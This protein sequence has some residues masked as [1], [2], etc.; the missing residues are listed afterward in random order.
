MDWQQLMNSYLLDIICY[1]IGV[2]SG[3]V[4]LFLIYK[5][6]LFIN[7]K[8]NQ[9]RSGEKE[10]QPAKVDPKDINQIINMSCDNFLQ[11]YG[12][13]RISI[14]LNA[15]KNISLTLVEDI[16]KAYYPTSNEPLYELS[17]KELIILMEDINQ[18]LSKFVNEVFDSTGFKV[19]F[20]AYKFSYNAINFLKKNNQTIQEKNFRKL[21][22]STIYQIAMPKDNSKAV[23]DDK[24]YFILNN[25]INIKIQDFLREVGEEARKAY[26]KDLVEVAH[27]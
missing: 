2:A 12:H 24:T 1:V 16:A 18:K 27:E 11:N 14:R 4:F 3:I 8:V 21:K 26:N 13:K 15:M 20:Q 19:A 17:I 22:I 9:K 7:K 6:T 23:S 25:Y 10:E 5:L